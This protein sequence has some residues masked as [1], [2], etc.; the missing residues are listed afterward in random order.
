MI[1]SFSVTRNAVA[2]AVRQPHFRYPT[3]RDIRPALAVMA[4]SSFSSG[5][6]LQSATTSN[7]HRS[8]NNRNHDDVPPTILEG[9][10]KEH[11]DLIIYHARQSQTSVSLQALMR[12]G[13]GEFLHK[14]F[15]ETAKDVDE[16]TATMRVLIQVSVVFIFCEK[17]NYYPG[18]RRS[19]YCISLRVG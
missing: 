5:I 15:G 12:T 18:C 7:D 6:T 1:R 9:V 19:V 11:S 16:H 10:S 13:R 17:E 2:K 14:T 4:S 8:L 3:S